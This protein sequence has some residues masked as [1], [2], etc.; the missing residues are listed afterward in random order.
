[1]FFPPLISLRSQTIIK[2]AHVGLETKHLLKCKLHGVPL[3]FFPKNFDKG[4]QMNAFSYSKGHVTFRLLQR[5]EMTPG[6]NVT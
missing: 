2:I 3:I 6:Q 4:E 1:M 5:G